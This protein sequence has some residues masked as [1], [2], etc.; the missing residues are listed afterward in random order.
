[1]P[2]RLIAI[3]RVGDRS[4]AALVVDGALEDLLIDPLA[5]TDAV[6][7][8]VFLAIAERPLKSLGG[9]VVRLGG[10]L[11]GFLKDGKPVEPGRV[12][13][14]EVSGFPG[15]GKLPPVRSKPTIKGRYAIATPGAP[16][17]NASRSIESGDVRDELSKLAEAAS[18]EAP[19]GT[20]FIL[21]SA[22]LHASADEIIYE[23]EAL[24]ETACKL[25][26]SLKETSPRI[27]LKAPTAEAAARREWPCRDSRQIDDR[28]GSFERLGVWEL[29]EL[30]QDPEVQL[31]GGGRMHIEETKALVAVDVDT[32]ASLSRQAGR[33]ANLDAA[34][35]LLRE[36][37]LRGLGGQVVVDFAPMAKSS[38]PAVRE[39]LGSRLGQDRRE[40]NFGGWTPQGNFELRRKRDRQPI[41]RSLPQ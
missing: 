10:S 38:R 41:S 2:T 15:R 35:A 7:G 28:P 26:C 25:A 39:A 17:I 5:A 18:A 3:D 8:A 37:R 4:I 29:V 27:L 31:P 21:R 36:L 19:D 22:C 12:M 40:V 6:P 33:A 14:V 34:S 16:G 23:L 11:K 24:A 30:L 20:G 1:M 32:G 13:L 9:T